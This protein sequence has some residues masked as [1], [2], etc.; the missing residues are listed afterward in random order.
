M[1]GSVVVPS[2]GAFL[3]KHLPQSARM[4]VFSSTCM[5]CSCVSFFLGGGIM[6]HCWEVCLCFFVDGRNFDRFPYD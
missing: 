6:V 1:F 4:V 2:F 3:L 5:C